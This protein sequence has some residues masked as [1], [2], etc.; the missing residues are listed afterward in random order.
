MDHEHFIGI[1]KEKSGIA[2]DQEAHRATCQTLHTLAQRISPGEADD[3]AQQLPEQLRECMTPDAPLEKFHVDEF[4]RR[5]EEYLGADHST[6]E[7]E[8]R[9][10]LAALYAAVG[11]EEFDDMRSQL[12][13][14]FQQLLDDAAAEAPP[15]QPLEQIPFTGTM[16]YDEFVRKVAD[17]AELDREAAVRAAAAVLEVLGMRI[18]AGE[19]EDLLPLLPTEL[20]VALVRSRRRGDR[21]IPMGL[22]RFLDEIKKREKVRPGQVLPRVEV[23]AHTRAVLTVLREAIGEKEW[24]DVAAQLPGEYR[25]LWKDA[26]VQ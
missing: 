4:I 5:I 15:P 6:A 1:V 23:V 8:A 16:T 2:D 7:R 21:A 24:H 3:L 11:P 22:E 26:Q 20:R 14:D 19:V 13:M 10:V 12:P 25:L 9:A 18:T 17:R